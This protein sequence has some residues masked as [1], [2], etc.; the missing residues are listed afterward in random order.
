MT[1]A[2]AS[3]YG[4]LAAAIFLGLAANWLI[5]SWTRLRIGFY[6]TIFIGLLVFLA[7]LARAHVHAPPDAALAPFPFN[8]LV[9]LDPIEVAATVAMLLT[10]LISGLRAM[11]SFNRVPMGGYI[12]VGA[13]VLALLAVEWFVM[14]NYVL[15]SYFS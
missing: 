14:V 11:A 2:I 6:V 8:L 9:A 10:V 13:M 1:A 3:L 4:A 7:W 15:P 12:T 5:R